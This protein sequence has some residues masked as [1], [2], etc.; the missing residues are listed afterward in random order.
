MRDGIISTVTELSVSV[1]V[2]DTVAGSCTIVEL[3]GQAD[4]S[5]HV[6]SEVLDAEV[7]RRPRRLVVDMSRLQF[8]DS[9]SLQILIHAHRRLL[10]DGCELLV[11]SPTPTVARLLQ[12][13]EAD[14]MLPVYHS[15]EE[16]LA[17]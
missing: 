1:T 6:M 3:A 7:A 9:A 10:D 14:Q 11:A 15:L 2:Q 12:L 13:T 5:T 4:V 8:M 17:R 16:A